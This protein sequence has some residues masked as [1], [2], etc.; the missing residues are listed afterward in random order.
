M[1]RDPR[2]ADEYFQRHK[3]EIDSDTEMN[4]DRQMFPL[5]A[6]QDGREIAKMAVG[7]VVETP[8]GRNEAGEEG[9]RGAA[10][11]ILPKGWRASDAA[12]I[13][14]ET[15]AKSVAEKLFPGANVT[16]WKRK[17]GQAG[18][19]GDKSW[20]VKSGAAIDV[21]PIKGM[22]F[23]QYVQRY[24]DAGYN[25]IEW[26]DET[27]PATA[28]QTGSTGPHWHVV[29]GKGG[30]SSAGGGSTSDGP[31]LS[32][33]LEY[34]E[35]FVAEKFGDR[36]PMYRQAVEDRAK[37]YI[38]QEHAEQEA[39]KREGEEAAWDDT[40]N[41]VDGLGDKFTDISQIRGWARLPPERRL[42]LRGWA[43]QNR[44]QAATGTEPQTDWMFYGELKRLAEED[45]RGFRAV[46]PAEIRRR[47]GNTEFKEAMGW[48]TG[49]KVDPTKSLTFD[50]IEKA[51]RSSLNASGL[52]TGDSKDARKDAP[53]VNQFLR[54]M[55]GWAQKEEARNGKWPTTEDIRKQS[56]RFLIEGLYEDESGTTQRGRAFQNPKGTIDP[57]IPDDIRGRIRRALGPK[58]TEAQI[59][60]AYVDGKGIDW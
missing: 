28:K 12:N 9:P 19:A 6:D 22:T 44:K 32:S 40:L 37:A 51:A 57:D 14:P 29:L 49:K 43:E 31:T 24:R 18:K 30:A 36:S 17:A 59:N 50:D 7:Q 45:P 54:R 55:M 35:G 8:G 10:T 47:L 23:D 42:Q 4:I 13:T 21:A 15:N 26:I 33:R 52:V 11:K 56:D 20:H 38:R 39:A 27:D 25:V 34:V 46:P 16:S 58:A 1:M 60:Q 41:Q 3:D 2:K 5:L 53:V 48:S